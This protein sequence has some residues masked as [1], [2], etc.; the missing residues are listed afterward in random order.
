MRSALC[1]A[2]LLISFAACQRDTAPVASS[3]AVAPQ[4]AAAVPAKLTLD[5]G[6]SAIC[7]RAWSCIDTGVFYGSKSQCLAACPSG[8]FLDYVCNGRCLCP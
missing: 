7:P 1:I 3:V 4:P 2:S 6:Q 8:C 5:Q